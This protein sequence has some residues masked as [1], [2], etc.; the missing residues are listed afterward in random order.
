MAAK[1]YYAALLIAC[2][3]LALELIVLISYIHLSSGD[4]YFFPGYFLRYIVIPSAFC[5][6][7]VI[8]GKALDTSKEFPIT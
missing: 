7:F 4:D 3:T 2:V 5:F 6:L 1:L 8:I